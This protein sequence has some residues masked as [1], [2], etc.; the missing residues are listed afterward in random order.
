MVFSS[1][2]S[3]ASSA[4]SIVALI[5]WVDL[6]RGHDALRPGEGYPGLEGRVLGVGAGLDEPLVHERRDYGRVAVVA[7]PPAWMP[8]ARTSAPACTSSS[9][10][11]SRGVAEVVSVAALRERRARGRLDGHDARAPCLLQVLPDEGEGDA[12]EVRARRR[13]SRRPRQDT[14]RPA[15]SAATLPARSR[16]GAGARG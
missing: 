9:S 14:R 12:G 16:S 15:P 10:A 3:L 6:G 13:R 11:S 8:L 7:R 4:R 5:A 1:P 2:A